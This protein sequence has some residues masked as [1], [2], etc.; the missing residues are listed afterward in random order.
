MNTESRGFS[1]KKISLKN[2]KGRKRFRKQVIVGDWNPE[3]LKEIAILGGEKIHLMQNSQAERIREKTYKSYSDDLISARMM[4]ISALSY[5]MTVRADSPGKTNLKIGQI[6]QQI[7]IFYQ[8]E[9]CT[10]RAITEGQYIKSS[11]LVKQEIE[12]LARITEINE[13]QEKE[14]RTPNVSRLSKNLR[15]QYGDMNGIAHVA[16]VEYLDLF[17]SIDKGDYRGVAFQPIF[18][19][20]IA[21]CLY[22]L[23]M[24][25]FYFITLE[26]ISVFE[27]LYPEDHEL[28]V[29][30]FRTMKLVT[31]LFNKED[32]FSDK[33]TSD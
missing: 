33:L 1:N 8:G 20:G 16:K 24:Y 21:R 26:G 15:E 7:V 5:L 12:I 10:E 3:E 31:D 19:A 22:E 9:T 25:I 6:L 4:L 32:F 11:A 2:S 28:L 30:P 17:S 18:N 27:Q 14:G 13:G 29:P 23:H